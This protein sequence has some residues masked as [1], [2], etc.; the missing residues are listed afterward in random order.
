[1]NWSD[2]LQNAAQQ[3]VDTRLAVYQAQHTPTSIDPNSG[4]SY[5]DGQPKTGGK[6]AGLSPTVLI[7]GGAAVLLLAV[8]LLKD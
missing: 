3:V 8:F 7:A 6:I 5:V 2:F 1:M 4:M